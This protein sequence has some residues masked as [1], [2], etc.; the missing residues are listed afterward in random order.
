MK[1]LYTESGNNDVRFFVRVVPLFDVV[2]ESFKGVPYRSPF[3]TE[4]PDMS[5]LEIVSADP[6]FK[7]SFESGATY[8]SVRE[9]AR[10]ELVEKFR[11]AD[12][13]PD[14]IYMS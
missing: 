13:G 10:I 12:G 2:R 14:V 9:V 3:G 5:Y 6:G 11:G 1:K 7:M 8:V 4:L